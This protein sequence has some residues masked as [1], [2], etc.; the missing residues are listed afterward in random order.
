M[1][2]LIILAILAVAYLAYRAVTV[3]AEIE[4]PAQSS[5]PESAPVVKTMSN[6][7]KAAIAISITVAAVVAVAFL[8]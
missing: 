8:M 4:L 7:V 3:E 6:S 1:K 5:E 2:I